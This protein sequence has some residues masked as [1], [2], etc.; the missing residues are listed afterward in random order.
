MPVVQVTM[1]EGRR[2]EQ[3]HAL[4]ARITS[5][6]EAV[7]RSAKVSASQFTKSPPM[8]G[9]LAGSPSPSFGRDVTVWMTVGPVPELSTDSPNARLIGGHSVLLS[10]RNSAWWAIAN[11]CPHRG[12]VLSDGLVQGDASRVRG[13]LRPSPTAR[14]GGMSACAWRPTLSGWST[15]SSR[16]RILSRHRV[17]ARSCW[18]TRG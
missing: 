15:T 3:M 18:P 11:I 1:I 4:R 10:Y 17:C 5:A 12:E 8:T 13:T 2:D 7:G 9:P 16:C 14:N 6:V